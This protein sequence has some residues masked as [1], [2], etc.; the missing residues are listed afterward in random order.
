MCPARE[1]PCNIPLSNGEHAARRTSAAAIP[2]LDLIP[3]SP[4][5]TPLDSRT[6]L[7]FGELLALRVR[8]EV[9]A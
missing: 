5:R 8:S 3:L 4:F 9:T 1:L 7:V 2:G 6:L